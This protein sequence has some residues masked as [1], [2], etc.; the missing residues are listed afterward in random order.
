[1]D[2]DVVER[3]ARSLFPLK[4]I[5]FFELRGNRNMSIT[6]DTRDNMIRALRNAETAAPIFLVEEDSLTLL[7]D[8][9][10]FETIMYMMVVSEATKSWI[11]KFSEKVEKERE[12]EKDDGSTPT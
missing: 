1:M 8:R 11:G 3:F 12:D 7:C 2:V 5:H 10:N 9:D 4:E 6:F